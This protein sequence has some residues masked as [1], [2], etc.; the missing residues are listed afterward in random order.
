[1]STRSHHKHTFV[2]LVLITGVVSLEAGTINAVAPSC[3]SVGAQ[4]TI[5]GSGFDSGTLGIAVGG[6]PASVI[7]VTS[8][9]ATFSVP[10]GA[11]LGPTTVTAT[12]P[13]SRNDRAME[14][15]TTGGRFRWAIRRL[16][17]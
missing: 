5:I 13:G 7:A 17:L 6:V 4:A 10:T 9:T 16:P 2:A 1:M 8:T 3:A 14:S 12:N 11:G 15:P